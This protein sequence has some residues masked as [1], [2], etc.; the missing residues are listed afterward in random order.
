MR[1]FGIMKSN[2]GRQT[3]TTPTDLEK[4]EVRLVLVPQECL[5]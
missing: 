5:F 2:D 3:E 4:I 1:A